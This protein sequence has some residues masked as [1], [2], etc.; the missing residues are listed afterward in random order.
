MLTA[1]CGFIDDLHHFDNEAFGI[2]KRE[3]DS[4]D[5]Q[6]Q[7]LLEVTYQA[8]EDAAFQWSGSRT[9]VFIG[10]GQQDQY[11][12]STSNLD[13]ISAYS[14]TGTTPPKKQTLNNF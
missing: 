10:A 4:M 14:V 8:L 13:A 6:Q 7:I 11:S 5:P 12:V 1:N 2:S 9:G 3:A